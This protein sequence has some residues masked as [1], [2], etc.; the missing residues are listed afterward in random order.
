MSEN[1]AL[2]VEHDERDKHD[3]VD[4][5]QALFHIYL[6]SLCKYVKPDMSKQW[7]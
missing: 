5:H 4:A 3:E 6:S 1:N 2:N 7:K